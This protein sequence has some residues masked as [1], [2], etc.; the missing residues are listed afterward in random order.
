MATLR[1]CHWWTWSKSDS[2]SGPTVVSLT[3]TP[4]K[5]GNCLITIVS[6]KPRENP[7]ITGCDT[8]DPRKPARSAA[9][10]KKAKPVRPASA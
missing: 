4:T 10:S 5:W 1:L 2:S 3:E 6:D 9:A 8:K 7:R